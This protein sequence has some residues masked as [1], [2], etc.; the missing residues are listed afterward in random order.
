MARA[1]PR[2]ARTNARGDA[3]RERLLAT[4][5]ELLREKGYAGLSI[6]ALCERADIAPTSVYWHFGSKAGLMEAV[7]A[8][9]SGHYVERI[10]ADAA[11]AS[12]PSERL[13]R[14][15]AGIRSLVTT[16]PL[17]SLTGVAVVGEGRH[18]TPELR[19]ALRRARE[20]E[21]EFIASE[22]ASE[23]RGD[24]AIGETLAVIALACT[25]YAALSYRMDRDVG[26]VDRILAGLRDA[27]E[28][29]A[30]GGDAAA[31]APPPGPGSPT[32]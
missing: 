17:G 30:G 5:V 18:V 11:E 16:Q 32:R 2:S 12:G 7:I 21:F 28:R 3:T 31:T 23:I 25:N 19:R 8:R 1:R 27:V 20:R 24:R 9:I 13:D 6:S 14:M 10:R 15:I 4:A 22:F 29:L 26:E